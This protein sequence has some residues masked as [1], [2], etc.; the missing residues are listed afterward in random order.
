MFVLSFH[1]DCSSVFLFL[2][3]FFLPERGGLATPTAYTVRTDSRRATNKSKVESKQESELSGPTV[4]LF[5]LLPC[6]YVV[7]TQKTHADLAHDTRKTF[8]SMFTENPKT[9]TMEL[10]SLLQNKE[11]LL[12]KWILDLHHHLCEVDLAVA[13]LIDLLHDPRPSTSP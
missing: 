3:L 4:V 11:Q 1:S 12:S 9:L 7:T 8:P 2:F 5:P 10:S 6:R 13:A